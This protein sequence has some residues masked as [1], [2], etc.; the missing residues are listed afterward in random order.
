MESANIKS[1][2]WNF[3]KLIGFNVLI[4]SI[5]FMFIGNDFKTPWDEA[6]FFMLNGSLQEERDIWNGYWAITNSRLFDT[7]SAVLLGFVCLVYLLKNRENV[8]AE[9]LSRT[10]LLV[11]SVILIMIS[12]SKGFEYYYHQ[13]PS[14]ILKPFININD[15]VSW[16]DV[17]TG[18]RKSFPSDHAAIS[19]V[20]VILSWRF[21]GRKYGI[22]LTIFA[23]INA[24]PRMVGGG[25][26]FGDV[27]IGGLLLACFISVWLIYS[28][29]LSLVRVGV[30]KILK[31]KFFHKLT[32]RLS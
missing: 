30:D 13:S 9:R 24:T 31:L 3:K 10:L 18:T 6:I 15:L 25:H 28:P 14:Q 8:F 20:S 19:F 1:M 7:F 23:L 5:I 12:I 32:S 16:L 29:F 21:F 17:K 4:I 27:W 2:S 11:I 26:W 22:F